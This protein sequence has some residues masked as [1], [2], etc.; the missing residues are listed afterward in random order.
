MGSSP[1]EGIWSDRPAGD[2]ALP[3]A[4][5]ARRSRVARDAPCVPC[6]VSRARRAVVCVAIS[7]AGTCARVLW[8]FSKFRSSPRRSAVGVTLQARRVSTAGAWCLIRSGVT[9]WSAAAGA[10][11]LAQLHFC[12]A[13]VFTGTGVKS[14]FCL[15]GS[16][17]CERHGDYSSV[18]RGELKPPTLPPPQE[19]R[20]GQLDGHP[21]SLGLSV[22]ESGL[23]SGGLSAWSLRPCELR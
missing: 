4:A 10:F 11:G 18:R 12:D 13:T 21:S 6:A 1:R 14:L 5:D 7:P 16:V 3:A 2:G 15:P 23:S 17:C 9:S 8:R 22:C 20:C 19:G